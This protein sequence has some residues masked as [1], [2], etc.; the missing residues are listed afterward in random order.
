[1]RGWKWLFNLC[2]EDYA[3]LFQIRSKT[4][5]FH[6]VP[7]ASAQQQGKYDDVEDVLYDA[8][9]G[10]GD[11]EALRQQEYDAEEDDHDQERAL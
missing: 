1:M 10:A 6:P 5:G 7:A 11:E 4:S 3:F 9:G 2:F 8:H